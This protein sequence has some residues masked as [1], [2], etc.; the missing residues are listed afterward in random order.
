MNKVIYAT[1][2]KELEIEGYLGSPSELIL[3]SDVIGNARALEKLIVGPC[4]L[5]D[6]V[7]EAALACARHDFR[8]VRPSPK[9]I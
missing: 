1:C 6:T 9:F 7:Q 3:S 4:G 8:Y 5:N 2:L